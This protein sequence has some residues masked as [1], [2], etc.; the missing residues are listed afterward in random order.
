MREAIINQDL[1][2]EAVS[3]GSVLQV[4]GLSYT[5]G[6]RDLLREVSVSL[7]GQGVSVIMGPNGAGKSLF[8]RVVHG[9]FEP[10]T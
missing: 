4:K 8:L 10:R 3:P 2:G 7:P 1:S 6:G 9:L 5:A